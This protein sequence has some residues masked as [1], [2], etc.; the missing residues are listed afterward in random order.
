MISFPKKEIAIKFEIIRKTMNLFMLVK[1][2]TVHIMSALYKHGILEL[3]D[4]YSC[5]IFGPTKHN[6]KR[7]MTVWSFHRC[8]CLVIFLPYC[9]PWEKVR[10]LGWSF[11][12]KDNRKRWATAKKLIN[13][14]Y[15]KNPKEIM[16]YTFSSTCMGF[17]KFL[18]NNCHINCTIR[19]P[20]HKFDM[21]WSI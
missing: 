4:T 5:P 11:T 13:C 19:R 10:E 14:I 17:N 18:L 15:K 8:C 12:H 16:S 6:Q 20:R 3:K 9:K 1:N 7:W 2:S 21:T